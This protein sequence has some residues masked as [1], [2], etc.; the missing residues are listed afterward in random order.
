[1]IDT[2]AANPLATVYFITSSFG[3]RAAVHTII[4][5]SEDKKKNENGSGEPKEELD[6]NE[7]VSAPTHMCERRRRRCEQRAASFV[8]VER[9]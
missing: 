8:S 1:M 9:R 5:K 2:C 6:C 3:G 4:Q 7:Q